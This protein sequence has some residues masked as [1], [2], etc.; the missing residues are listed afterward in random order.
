MRPRAGS[1][2]ERDGHVDPGR[3]VNLPPQTSQSKHGA[4]CSCE[5]AV[6]Q[7]DLR[8]TE[9]KSRRRVRA[10]WVST[11]RLN[12]ASTRNDSRRSGI[13]P[14]DGTYRYRVL[15]VYGRYNNMI[16]TL[17]NRYETVTRQLHVSYTSVTRCVTDGSTQRNAVFRSRF[18]KS[19]IVG[20]DV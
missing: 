13:I 2:R 8:S 7:P 15:S 3:C 14:Q 10:E 19:G 20:I 12:H 17:H 5:P 6:I 18:R 1:G 16:R 11:G 4:A 9:D